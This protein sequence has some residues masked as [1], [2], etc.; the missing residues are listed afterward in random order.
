MRSGKCLDD[1]PADVP[2][3]TDADGVGILCD[4]CGDRGRPPHYDYLE[5]LLKPKLGTGGAELVGHIADFAYVVCADP[6]CYL[7]H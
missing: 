1:Q 3:L 5:R 6:Q 7:Y 4:P 2:Q